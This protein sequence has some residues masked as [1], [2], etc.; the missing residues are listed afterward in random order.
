ML[1]SRETNRQMIRPSEQQKE[2][3]ER[4]HHLTLWRRAGPPHQED[5]RSEIVSHGRMDTEP[6]RTKETLPAP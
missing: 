1:V 4:L 6:Q 3:R 2:R 5:H